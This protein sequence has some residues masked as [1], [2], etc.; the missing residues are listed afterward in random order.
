MRIC[1]KDPRE[2]SHLIDDRWKL[3]GGIIVTAVALALLLL[4]MLF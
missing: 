2:R 3:R 1:P 4:M